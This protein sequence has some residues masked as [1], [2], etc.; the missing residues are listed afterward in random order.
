MLE[1]VGVLLEF[2]V[3]WVCWGPSL[4]LQYLPLPHQWRHRKN[5]GR[6][7]SPVP[8]LGSSLPSL[9]STWWH[10][11]ETSTWPS[12]MRPVFPDLWSYQKEEEEAEEVEGEEIKEKHRVWVDTHSCPSHFQYA[13]SCKSFS[14]HLSIPASG[15]SPLHSQSAIQLWLE[16]INFPACICQH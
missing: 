4:S 11:W 16:N 3:I 8:R 9:L 6:P 13:W 14:W 1:N 5:T 12:L 7:I 10:T 15:I 2:H